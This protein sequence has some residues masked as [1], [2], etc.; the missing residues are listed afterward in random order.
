MY[1]NLKIRLTDYKICVKQKNSRAGKILFGKTAIKN[2]KLR[3]MNYKT[4][5]RKS[6]PELVM[7]QILK[8]IESGQMKPGDKLPTE[9]RLS[10]MFGVGRSTIREATSTLSMLGYLQSIQG[11]GCFVRENLD[12]VKAT[13]IA[14][15]D[16]QAATNIIDLV[17]VREILECNAAR[18]AARRADSEDIERIQ[19]ACLKMKETM[20]GLNRFI[21]D[22][23]DFHIALARAS[24]NQLILEMMKHI[25]EKV[26]KEY[27]KFR[28]KTLFQRDQAVLTAEQI[29]N[30]VARG[31]GEKAASSMQEH[32]NLVTTEIKRKLPDVKWIKK[33]L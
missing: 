17:E 13:G 5:K 20:S 15:Q 27:D 4:V 18:L 22:D 7:K 16:M 25:V 19:N 12:P 23:F 3:S 11:K 14:L 32:L 8:S 28:I 29:V 1:D 21:E 6:T 2:N 30:F 31:E 10:E 9:H 24:K 26:H 33:K